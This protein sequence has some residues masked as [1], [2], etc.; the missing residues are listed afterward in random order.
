MK[1]SLP[2]NSSG[3]YNGRWIA[4]LYE[5]A[6]D[7][8]RTALRAFLDEDGPHGLTRPASPEWIFR[9]LPSSS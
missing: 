7:V 3:A 1:A 4:G 9:R 8:V 6:A 5:D 2:P